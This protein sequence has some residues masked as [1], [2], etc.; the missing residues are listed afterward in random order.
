MQID[1]IQWYYLKPEMFY[2]MAGTSL[3]MTKVSFEV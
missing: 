3:Q 2:V 1:I